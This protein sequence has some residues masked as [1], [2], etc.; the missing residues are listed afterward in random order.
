MDSTFRSSESL[1]SLHSFE[2]LQ[3]R[4]NASPRNSVHLLA[5]LSQDSARSIKSVTSH[6]MNQVDLHTNVL[7]SK[8]P[9][10]PEAWWSNLIDL[11]PFKF[12]PLSNFGVDLVP[13]N[14]PRDKPKSSHFGTAPTRPRRRPPP[15]ELDPRI[16]SSRKENLGPSDVQLSS[17]PKVSTGMAELD[18]SSPWFILNQF[19]TP[20]TTPLIIRG[21]KTSTS[22]HNLSRKANN[23]TPSITR[24]AKD[25]PMEQVE[26]QPSLLSIKKKRR[27]SFGSLGRAFKATQTSMPHTPPPVTHM[28]LKSDPMAMIGGD[29]NLSPGLQRR[30][31]FK[32][33]LFSI[34]TSPKPSP[35]EVD[36]DDRRSPSHPIP[37]YGNRAV[38]ESVQGSVI[39]RE[40]PRQIKPRSRSVSQPTQSRDGRSKMGPSAPGSSKNIPPLPNN[41]G[42]NLVI[43]ERR[44]HSP[45]YFNLYI[46]PRK[47]VGSSPTQTLFSVEDGIVPAPITPS[48]GS[49]E[50]PEEIM[51]LPASGSVRS[52]TADLDP[53]GAGE[54]ASFFRSE[55]GAPTDRIQATLTF[56]RIFSPE[57]I[58]LKKRPE[59][60]QARI[61]HQVPDIVVSS[62]RGLEDLKRRN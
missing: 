36:S 54:P 33:R 24:L 21:S 40:H 44:T 39:L 32:S 60:Q 61:V 46:P 51:H 31:T 37:R 42:K 13:N 12:R 52:L 48:S 22:V 26:N 17:G 10:G 16:V 11:K 58:I 28:W 5:Y 8:I 27:S 45:S 23:A 2:S 56:H 30:D 15:L 20:P 35:R 49:F 3:K 53:F 25:C 55:Y 59:V 29:T 43:P 19:P 34:G 9:D 6:E 57:T 62:S 14:I 38:S 4:L 47:Q 41:L 18:L 50:H 7:P 1:P